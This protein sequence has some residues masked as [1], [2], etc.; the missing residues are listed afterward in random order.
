M[1][2]W[3]QRTNCLNSC[4]MTYLSASLEAQTRL[5]FRHRH[6]ADGGFLPIATGEKF[7]V[8]NIDHMK[9]NEAK[10]RHPLC[11]RTLDPMPDRLRK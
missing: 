8:D 6:G 11:S 2:Y 1:E 9:Q 10:H 5:G 4:W 7:D 3:A